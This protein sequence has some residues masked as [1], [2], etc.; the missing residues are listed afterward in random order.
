MTNIRQS[1]K[2]GT[3]YFIIE[4]KNN[5]H[6][7]AGDKTDVNIGN[8]NC[9]ARCSNAPS[10]YKDT[11]CPTKKPEI[12]TDL[13]TPQIAATAKLKPNYEVPEKNLISLKADIVSLKEF[14]MVEIIA[15]NKRIKSVGET[16]SHDKV[17]HIIERNSS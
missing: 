3:S 11:D 9:F 8:N 6:E 10:P 17:K 15:V 2:K 1:I 4:A 16:Q 14:I 13:S 5:D 7:K 12:I